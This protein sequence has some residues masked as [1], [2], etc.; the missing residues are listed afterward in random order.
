M[1]EDNF[2]GPLYIAKPIITPIMISIKINISLSSEYGIIIIK[3]MTASIEQINSTGIDLEI[4]EKKETILFNIWNII[5]ER[6]KTRTESTIIPNPV[7]IKKPRTIIDI[8]EVTTIPSEDPLR[9]AK[10]IF[11]NRSIILNIC[12]K[13]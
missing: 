12:F 2:F 9:S 11:F 1:I 8:T 6:N 5:K 10:I 3:K 13:S 7:R 4:V